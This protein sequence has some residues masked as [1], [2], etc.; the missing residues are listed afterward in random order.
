[1]SFTILYHTVCV[2][3]LHIFKKKLNCGPCNLCTYN[4]IYICSK[5]SIN[6]NIIL[7]LYTRITSLYMP[8]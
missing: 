3:L 1:M 2:T 5:K 6:T 8:Y 4:P 7:D